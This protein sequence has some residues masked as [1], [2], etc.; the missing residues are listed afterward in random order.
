MPDSCVSC[1]AALPD[2]SQFCPQCGTEQSAAETPQP[3]VAPTAIGITALLG[4]LGTI[5][6]ASAVFVWNAVFTTGGD[7]ETATALFGAIALTVSAIG[8]IAG[9]VAFVNFLRQ[10][11]ADDWALLTQAIIVPVWL[12][13]F[14]AVIVTITND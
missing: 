8:V 4:V 1:G 2:G 14:L 6:I 12:F 10:R 13:V 9:D 11:A 5:F 7:A 3:A